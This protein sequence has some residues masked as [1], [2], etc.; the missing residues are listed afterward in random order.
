MKYIAL[1]LLLIFGFSCA[2]APKKVSNKL[3]PLTTKQVIYQCYG[4]YV[5]LLNFKGG[6]GFFPDDNGKPRQCVSKP[7]KKIHKKP[8]SKT[9]WI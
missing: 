1:S 8:K 9:K 3:P 6:M 2:H 5:F 7:E 4:G